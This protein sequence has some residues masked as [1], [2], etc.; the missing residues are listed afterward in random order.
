MSKRK[1]MPSTL[2]HFLYE[3]YGSLCIKCGS[4]DIEIHYHHIKTKCQGGQETPEN[5]IPLCICCHKEWHC[6]NSNYPSITIH[7][8]LNTPPLPH[9]IKFLTLDNVMELKLKDCLKLI[10]IYI[11]LKKLPD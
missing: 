3:T 9:I 10:N 4:K 7:E 2:E 6:L 1:R 11:E 8:W 5:L